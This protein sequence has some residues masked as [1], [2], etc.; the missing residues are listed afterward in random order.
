MPT[1]CCW[2]P[3]SSVGRWPTRSASPT[4]SRASRARR[5][6]SRPWPYSRGSSTFARAV[7]RGRRLYTWNTNPIFLFLISASRFP[8]REP[9]SSPSS[10]YLPDVGTSRHP[11]IFISVDFPD[12]DGP[13][14]AVS[15]PRR[16]DRLT[17]LRAGTP[18]VPMVYTLVTF[19]SSIIVAIPRTYRPPPPPS[20]GPPPPPGRLPPP[21]LPAPPPNRPRKAPNAPPVVALSVSMTTYSAS[22]TPSSTTAQ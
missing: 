12:P 19:C 18:T 11:S 9:T 4:R 17:P 21:K 8:P 14:T 1:R 6:R 20:P 15:S 7:S 3:D 13:M 16:K 5:F 10:T 22:A 2:P